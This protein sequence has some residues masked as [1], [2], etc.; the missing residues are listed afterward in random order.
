[1]PRSAVR[2]IPSQNRYA[3]LACN[4]QVEADQVMG[5]AKAIEVTVFHLQ[6]QA[7]DSYK[8]K[9]RSLIANLKDKNNPFLRHRVLSGEIEPQVFAI[10]TPEEMM[11]D[12]R[13]KIVAQVQKANMEEVGS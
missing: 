7:K 12:E 5:I 2:S 3:A 11:S 9:L 13:K 4:T 8:S 1:M 6:D 10:M